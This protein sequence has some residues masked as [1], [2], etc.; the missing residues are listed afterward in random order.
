MVTATDLL[1]LGFRRTD[2]WED[3]TLGRV[4]VRFGPGFTQVIVYGGD[5]GEIIYV[6]A[7]KLFTH[8]G[9]SPSE[10]LSFIRLHLGLDPISEVGGSGTP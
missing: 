7:K 8:E 5:T 1:S 10:D 2:Q 9:M 3:W 6:K 4:R